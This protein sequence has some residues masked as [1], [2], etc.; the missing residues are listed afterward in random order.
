MGADDVVQA[1][2][3]TSRSEG[4]RGE[5]REL[6]AVAE[7]W[8]R[9]AEADG[10]SADRLTCRSLLDHAAQIIEEDGRAV[11]HTPTSPERGM[12]APS[13]AYSGLGEMTVY[14]LADTAA[15]Q[16]LETALIGMGQSCST[17]AGL[18]RLETVG[19]AGER[20]HVDTTQ[21][22]PPT[23]LTLT[24]HSAD[25]NILVVH[26]SSLR[27]GS[28]KITPAEDEVITLAAFAEHVR[29]QSAA[30]LD[31]LVPPD[32]RARGVLD[33]TPTLEEAA[34]A[35]R[36]AGF[37]AVRRV[38]DGGP[39]VS[40]DQ[41]TVDAIVRE[42]A[43]GFETVETDAAARL[44][45]IPRSEAE[46]LPDGASPQC[47]AHLDQRLAEADAHGTVAAL[48]R[49]P[50]PE[51]MPE[52]PAETVALI[53]APDME[54]AA[55]WEGLLLNEIANRCGDLRNGG[56]GDA[57]SLGGHPAQEARQYRL[58]GDVRLVVA[59]R[60]TLLAYGVAI[61]PDP[62]PGSPPGAG[63][64]PADVLDPLRAVMDA[65]VREAGVR[66]DPTTDERGT[67]GPAP[68]TVGQNPTLE[69]E[70]AIRRAEEHIAEMY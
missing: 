57:T 27:P 60:G 13:L 15:R 40:M 35:A 32:E 70:A 19:W 44:A 1:L 24:I 66:P 61:L 59:R 11:V 41:A 39:L 31:H 67:A 58:D 43:T 26:E 50:E 8:R 55:A 3:A 21:P 69:E 53:V 65:A 54:S 56:S 47:R 18:P 20:V 28:G 64:S 33:R 14:V 17:P 29:G 52:A 46:R 23:S 38:D 36:A 62:E 25:A 45:E 30:V 16:R 49:R 12:Q 5:V 37:H 9:H 10:F 2:E 22:D 6:H 51:G 68:V 34:A 42:H 48:A 63:E 7:Y 4:L